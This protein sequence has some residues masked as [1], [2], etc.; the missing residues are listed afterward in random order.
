MGNYKE[1]MQY[2]Q[3]GGKGMNIIL[4]LMIFSYELTEEEAVRKVLE[5]PLILSKIEQIKGVEH[6]KK[7]IL[8][9]FFPRLKSFFSYSYS[10]FVDRM[11]QYV[12]VGIDPNTLEP[13]FKPVEVEFGKQE[14]RTLNISLEWLLFSGLSRYYFL[15][16]I[17]TLKSLKVKEREL[18]E[19]ELEIMTRMLYSQGL[20]FKEAIKRYDKIIGILNTHKKIAQ[21]RYK[22]G[23]VLELDVMR[24][25]AEIERVKAQRAEFEKFLTKTLSSLK[26]LCGIEG[27][28]ELVDSLSPDTFLEEKE[29]SRIDIEIM[30]KNLE[31]LKYQRKEKI[32]K[33]LPKIFGKIDYIYGRPYGFFR[34]EW[35]DYFVYSIYLSWDIFTFGERI[36]EM[37]KKDSELKSLKYLLKFSK[38]KQEEEIL[39][40]EKEF[41]AAIKSYKSAL[42]FLKLIEKTLEISNSQ[43]RE[44]YISSM[45]FLDVLAKR[46][47]AEIMYLNSVLNLKKAKLFYD[48]V[49]YGV[50]LNI[51]GG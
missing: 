23:Y 1:G 42:K 46:L 4:F 9:S 49:I 8:S 37:K 15:K 41:K 2:I 5:N 13:I 31:M 28:I 36:F 29:V 43:Y 25:E 19:K 33:F 30:N 21:E 17:N 38:E 39:S 27:K 35:G 48:S 10:T 50:K 44:G 47:E 12:L 6:E 3:K 11:T 7:M 40:A 26:T 20:F 45:E 32:S 24:A 22:K 14:R 16:I 18:K 51:Q 34:D